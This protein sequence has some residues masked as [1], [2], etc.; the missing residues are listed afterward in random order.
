MP[1]VAIVDIRMPPNHTDEGLV[2]AQ[3]IRQR[4][5][6]IGIVILSEHLEAG[7]ATR[8]LAESPERLGYLLKQR[9]SDVDEFVGTLHR[10]TPAARRST[11]RSCRGCWPPAATAR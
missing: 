10:V 7:V 5:P 2:A 6:E 8:V 4:H 9:V 3:E 1:D 11:R